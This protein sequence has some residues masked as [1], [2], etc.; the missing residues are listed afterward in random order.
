[1]LIRRYF[2]ITSVSTMPAAVM[3]V[4]V[5]MPEP[6]VVSRLA[7][8]R[9]VIGDIARMIIYDH[10]RRI[11]KHRLRLHIRRMRLY[12]YW[13]RLDIDAR[14]RSICTSIYRSIYYWR[15]GCADTDRPIDPRAAAG[16]GG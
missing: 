16:V 15:T 4:P 6:V 3:V 7:V 10:R 13:R 14:R 8:M 2:L 9:P 11:D 1:M 12:I 5:V